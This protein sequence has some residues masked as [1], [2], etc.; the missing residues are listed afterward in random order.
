M[1]Q[2][3]KQQIH[4]QILEENPFISPRLFLQER[5]K[6]L[7][8]ISPKTKP[9]KR[10]PARGYVK[11]R[12]KTKA[13]HIKANKELLKPLIPKPDKLFWLK[14]TFP[15]CDIKE[16]PLQERVN[17]FWINKRRGV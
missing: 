10:D 7:S 17:K 4:N 12:E 11:Q 9:Y 2:T 1:H 15:N 3:L 16:L 13:W 5:Q 14:K 6:R 8:K